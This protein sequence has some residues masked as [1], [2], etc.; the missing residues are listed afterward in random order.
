MFLEQ[1]LPHAGRR[2]Q[3]EGYCPSNSPWHW[4][5]RGKGGFQKGKVSNT[6][7]AMSETPAGP[8]S[9]HLSSVTLQLSSQVA[10]F[11]AGLSMDL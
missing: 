1:L 8:L 11:V 6:H 7:V 4:G 3:C 9:S 5:W 2:V 10:V